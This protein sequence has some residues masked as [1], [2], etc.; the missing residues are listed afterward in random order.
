MSLVAKT[1]LRGPQEMI[2]SDTTNEAGE[3]SNTRRTSGSRCDSHAI[4]L[5]RYLA[6]TPAWTQLHCSNFVTKR[7]IIIT[8]SKSCSR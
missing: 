1:D 3:Y 2:E 6:A 7:V 4:H 8:S 5:L